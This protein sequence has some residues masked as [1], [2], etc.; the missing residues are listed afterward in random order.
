MNLREYL[1]TSE[2]GA[3]SRLAEQLGVSPSFL[4]QMASGEAAISHKRCVQLEFLTDG[5]VSR[6]DTRPDDW[7][8]LWPELAALTTKRRAA[9]PP[10]KKARHKRAPTTS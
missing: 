5:A 2:R 3:A 9:S 4:S 8:E 10:P 7:Q 1:D 6:K